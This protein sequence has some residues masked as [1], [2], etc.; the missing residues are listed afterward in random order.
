VA[1]DLTPGASWVNTL[2]APPTLQ[3]MEALKLV[4]DA[5]LAGLHEQGRI[6]ADGALLASVVVEGQELVPGYVYPGLRRR[7]FRLVR[8]PGAEA[9]VERVLPGDEA[10]TLYLATSAD[11][12]RFWLSGVVLLEENG[13]RTSEM[14]P[15]PKG[16][17]VLTNAPGT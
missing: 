11:G 12:R 5:S 4:R 16:V 14:L 1:P 13:R 7:P 9:A 17:T 10:G 6:P 8:V 3:T 15:G 2:D